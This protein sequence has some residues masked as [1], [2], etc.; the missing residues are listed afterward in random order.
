MR[1][2]RP[3]MIASAS[4][5]SE[6]RI[7]PPSAIGPKG[8]SEAGSRKIPD[9]IMLP[10]T[11]AMQAVSPSLPPEVAPVR[12]SR[13]CG[14]DSITGPPPVQPSEPVAPPSAGASDW[15]S[16]APGAASGAALSDVIAPR[17]SR[18]AMTM[19]R[20]SSSGATKRSQ[21]S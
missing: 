8:A 15:L 2:S 14:A 1:D 20:I 16:P 11:S 5:P 3:K 4:A 6:V 13:L 12:P 9:P 21:R 10:T 7:Q 17:L 18:T 19:A